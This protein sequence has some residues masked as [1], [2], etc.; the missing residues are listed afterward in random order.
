MKKN[1]WYVI[2]GAPHAGKT[3]LV[4]ELKKMGHRVVW[5]AA[6]V[7]IDEEI[8][9]GEKLEEIRKDE[10]AFQKKILEIKIKNEERESQTEIIFWDRGIP[11]SLAYF[12]M[13][14]VT[15]DEFLQSA[16]KKSKYAKVFLLSPLPYKKDYARVENEEQQKLIHTLLKKAYKDCGQEVI[17]I[18][19]VGLE[20]R[21]GIILKNL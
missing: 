15:D 3:T 20:E 19:D 17:E 18:G 8:E 21:L 14:G 4:E 16:S 13:L 1:N 7:Y 10:L 6:R 9:K 5:E 12:E 11:D 2:T